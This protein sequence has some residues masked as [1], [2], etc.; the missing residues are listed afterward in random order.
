[1]NEKYLNLL[2]EVA[3]TVPIFAE[4]VMDLNRE[5]NDEQ[6]LKTAET[7]RNDYQHLYDRMNASD[8]D[9]ETLTKSDFA[10]FLVGAFI[11]SRNLEDR[12]KMQRTALNGYKIDLIPKLDRIV[13]ETNT[14]EEALALA[15][16]IFQVKEEVN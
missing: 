14:T 12:I 8:F 13:N 11:I 6:G 3:H 9:A 4:Q 10:K 7:M 1:M 15:N 5:K 2:K 16:E